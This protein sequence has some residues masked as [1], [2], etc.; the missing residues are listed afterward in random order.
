MRMLADATWPGRRIANLSAFLVL[1]LT[2]VALA[3]L[4]LA[5]HAAPGQGATAPA[6]APAHAIGSQ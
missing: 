1:V 6:A 2:V 5:P 3:V 4:F